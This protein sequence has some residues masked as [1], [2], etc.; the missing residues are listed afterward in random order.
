MRRC[1]LFG[2]L[3]PLCASCAGTETG[4]PPASRVSFALVT[5]DPTV[6]STSSGS[7]HLIRSLRVSF[8]S[9]ALLDCTGHDVATVGTA[10]EVDL[11]AGANSVSIPSGDYCGVR[12]DMS[13]IDSSPALHVEGVRSDAISFTID[14]SNPL[15]LALN[16]TTPFTVHA[17]E[18]LLVSFDAAR[19]FGGTY[20]LDAPA[21]GGHVIIDAVSNSAALVPFETQVAAELHRD[22]NDDGH[23]DHSDGAAIASGHSARTP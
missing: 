22:L 20:L 16:S 18:A 7:G 11:V 2:L 15:A 4:N 6:A 8:E 17:D 14:D 9:M 5:S 13:P 21:A 1:F 23:V 10:G 12:I 3:A 19:W